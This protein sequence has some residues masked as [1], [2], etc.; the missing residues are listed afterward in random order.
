[1]RSASDVFRSALFV[2]S[3][4]G[5]LLL[6]TLAG[7]IPISIQTAGGVTCCAQGQTS[8][9]SVLVTNPIDG[10]PI[11][12]LGNTGPGLPSEWSFHFAGRTLEGDPNACTLNSPVGMP[13]TNLGNGI[14]RI[15][16]AIMCPAN[17]YELN[18]VIEINATVS[19]VNYR[20][21]GLGVATRAF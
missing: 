5:L 7:A 12:N 17:G 10:T 6:P 11:A 16:G 2:C 18:Y 20:G 4:V 15:T 19:G 8:I 3:F 21:S 13:F 14:Y 1:M 9:I